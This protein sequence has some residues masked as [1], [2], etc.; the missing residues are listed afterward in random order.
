MI[1][2]M[3]LVLLLFFI[4]TAIYYKSTSTADQQILEA[5]VRVSKVCVRSDLSNL[6]KKTQLDNII[7]KSVDSIKVKND[8]ERQHRKS[9][10]IIMNCLDELLS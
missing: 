1:E 7:T 9:L 4:L 10:V 5:L 3:A 6:S 8:R 2:Y